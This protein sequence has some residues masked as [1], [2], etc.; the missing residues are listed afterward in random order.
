MAVL[1]LFAVVIV[2]GRVASRS[3]KPA[4]SPEPL[5]T[6]RKPLSPERPSRSGTRA[7]NSVRNTVSSSTGASRL[8]ASRQ[9]PTQ[10]TIT[11]ASFKPFNATVEVTVGGH[12]NARREAFGERNRDGSA[13]GWRRRRA[14]EHADAGTV[15]DRRLGATGAPPEPHAQS[16]RFCR[17]LRQRFRRRQHDQQRRQRIEQRAAARTRPT[18]ALATRSTASA[19]RARRFCWTAWRTYPSSASASAKTFRWTR[20]RNISVI[21]NNYSAR[22]R[23]RLRRRRQ[24]DHESGNQ[25]HPRIG[26]GVQPPLGLH[27]E[28][29]CQRRSKSDFIQ[30]GGTGDLPEPKGTYTRNQFGYAAGGPI[31][32]NKLFIFESTEWT[33]VRSA[34]TETEESIRSELHRLDAREHPGLLQ[35]VWPNDIEVIGNSVHGGRYR[36]HMHIRVDVND[37]LREPNPLPPGEWHDNH[38]DDASRYSIPS[39]SRPPS[40]PA[41][42]LPKTPTIWWV[43]WTITPPI[44]PRCFS[45]EAARAPSSSPDPTLTAPIPNTIR[46]PHI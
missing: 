14:G 7:T 22:V 13:G 3:L 37:R 33:R 34:A 15:A 10:V 12:V 21:T 32:K 4:R 19:N 9:Q 20:C 38:P 5:W 31:M 46:E 42:A 43:A 11:S 26:V 25:Q 16:L 24:R 35:N 28:H 29:L 23:P 39:T 30:G 8:R 18:A 40:T 45:A 41:A 44:R 2:C 6:R 1:G 36:G 27:G 17:D